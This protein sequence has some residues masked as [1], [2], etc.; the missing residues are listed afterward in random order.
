MFFFVTHKSF[1]SVCTYLIPFP[2]YMQ[3]AVL[4]AATISFCWRFI[5]IYLRGTVTEKKIRGQL[6]HNLRGITWKRS[7]ALYSA[8]NMIYHCWSDKHQGAKNITLLNLNGKLIQ[9]GHCFN[10]NF[11]LA[12]MQLSLCA[13]SSANKNGEACGLS[14]TW[15]LMTLI[16]P[17]GGG[18]S[19]CAHD[20]FQKLWRMSTLCGF[21]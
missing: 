6:I 15:I 12:C 2:V 13:M 21:C 18:R 9:T 11:F 10:W 17:I 8:I 4:W 20:T 5:H 19:A 16:H 3:I 7:L 1:V 14:K